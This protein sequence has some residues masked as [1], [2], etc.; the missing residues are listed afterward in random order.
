MYIVLSIQLMTLKMI[1]YF[2]DKKQV[3]KEVLIFEKSH[4]NIRV[5][6]HS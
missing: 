4:L 5:S 1:T 2:K 3:E 6:R